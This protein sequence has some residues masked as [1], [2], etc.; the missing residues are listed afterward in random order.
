MVSRSVL[1]RKMK[2]FNGILST[3]FNDRYLSRPVNRFNPMCF[4]RNPI[5]LCLLLLLLCFS[6][7]CTVARV[8]QREGLFDHL[9]KNLGNTRAE[10]AGVSVTWQQSFPCS[11]LL[12]DIKRL[13]AQNYTFA[14]ARSKVEQAAMQYGQVAASLGPSPVSVGGKYE[15]ERE[16]EDDGHVTH[17]NTYTLF[18]QFEWEADVWGRL[19]AKKKASSLLLEEQQALARQTLLGLQTRLVSYWIRHQTAVLFEKLVEAQQKKNNQLLELTRFKAG[20]GLGTRLDVLEQ[21]QRLAQLEQSAATIHINQ[22]TSAN[23]Y[24]ILLGRS[25][26]GKNLPLETLPCLTPLS[27]LPCPKQLLSLRPDLSAAFAALGAADHEVAAAIADRLPRIAFGFSF[28][29]SG[30]SPASIGND[31]ALSLLA[32]L[33]TPVF[34]AGRKAM[35]VKQRKAEAQTALALLQQ[36]MLDA[37]LEIENSLARERNLFSRLTLFDRELAIAGQTFDEAMFRYV[38]GEETFLSVL[39][40]D[41]SRDRLE[42][43]KMGCQKELL[44]NRAQLLQSLGATVEALPFEQTADPDVLPSKALGNF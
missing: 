19:R 30:S 44:L 7:G 40:A 16:T 4:L 5:I 28:E 33:L 17:T 14:A 31:S 29:V 36:T 9:P 41:I 24:A 6:C 39:L 42:Q 26:S 21:T 32:N 8:E 12:K 34:D 22:K 10:E 11:G 35:M 20:L 2:E 38:N 3:F 37:L 27:S 25:P 43:D 13:K 23:A 15:N 18:A 1:G